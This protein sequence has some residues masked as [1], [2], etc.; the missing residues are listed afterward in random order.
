VLHTVGPP[1][2]CAPKYPVSQSQVYVPG[3]E[4]VQCAWL[5]QMDEERH[6]FTSVQVAAVPEVE[7][8][9]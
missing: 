8:P 2:V 5:P 6:S 3:G 1:V 9:E 4:L 7:A